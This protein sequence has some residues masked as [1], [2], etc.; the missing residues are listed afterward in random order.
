MKKQQK[1]LAPRLPELARQKL[2]SG[3]GHKSKKTTASS[4]NKTCFANSR[5]N[6]F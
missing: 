5:K 4:V 1:N 3:G 6:L 2:K